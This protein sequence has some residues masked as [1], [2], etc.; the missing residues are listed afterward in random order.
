MRLLFFEL[1]VR[2]FCSLIV[3]SVYPER[4]KSHKDSH[5]WRSASNSCISL[6]LINTRALMQARSLNRDGGHFCSVAAWFDSW[7]DARPYWYRSLLQQPNVK[8]MASVGSFYFQ[9]RTPSIWSIKFQYAV[10]T[11][12]LIKGRTCLGRQSSWMTVSEFHHFRQLI[13]DHFHT[14]GNKIPG[15]ACVRIAG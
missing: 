5:S 1:P 14:S 7:I 13:A 11:T 15:I 10:T 9:E 2:R 8:Y 4:V 6:L 12:S 3:T